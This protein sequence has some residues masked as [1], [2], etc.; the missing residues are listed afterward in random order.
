[1]KRGLGLLLVVGAGSMCGCASSSTPEAPP[2]PGD[3]AA[4][5]DATTIDSPA[6]TTPDASTSPD[7]SDAS[8]E[9]G[10][11]PTADGGDGGPPPVPTPP[12]DYIWYVLD[13]TSGTTA[14]DSSSHHFD[15]TN[16]QNVTW[17]AGA[18]FDG[19]NGNCG[20]TVVDDSYRT[21]PI[22]ITA[23]LTPQLRTDGNIGLDALQPFPPNAI[24]NDVP[25]VGGYGIGMNV[26][27]FDGG[28]SGSALEAEGV[29]PCTTAGLCVANTTQNAEAVDADGDASFSCTSNSSCD[30]GFAAASEYLVTLVVS[31]APDGGATPTA[32]IFVNGALFDSTDAIVPPAETSS[33]LYLGCHN[34]DNGYATERVFKGRIRDVRV[35]QRD[36]A[37]DEIDQLYR[38]G[39]VLQAPPLPDGGADA[40]GD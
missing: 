26:W 7:A 4:I 16:L 20:S 36:L 38:N 34:T 32:R 29:A 12:P 6:Q 28:V 1:M 33:S 40:G 22:T 9:G 39:P 15:V 11:V 31:P 27:A 13:E 5:T 35:Y 19:T 37:S 30:Q 25:G 3:D 8:S 17:S 18:N 24:S 14:H 2:A 21:P 23:W 10:P